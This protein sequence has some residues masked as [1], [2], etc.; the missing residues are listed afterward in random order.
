MSVD[1]Y[2]DSS[3]AFWLFVSPLVY[4]PTGEEPE[5]LLWPMP[6]QYR[7]G[8]DTVAIDS[9]HLRVRSNYQSEELH[10]AIVRYGYSFLMNTDSSQPFLCT[11]FCHLQRMQL[12]KF[13]LKLLKNTL[14]LWYL[15]CGWFSSRLRRMRVI[16]WLYLLMVLQFKLKRI[17]FMEYIMH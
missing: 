1:T 11:V 7:S 15:L 14:N 12:R 5:V 10:N 3:S 13:I 2:L 16:L 17:T 4:I 9:V 8:N 6:A